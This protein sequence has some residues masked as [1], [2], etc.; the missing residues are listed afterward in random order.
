[1]S[2]ILLYHPFF[3]QPITYIPCYMLKREIILGCNAK[4]E[5]IMKRARLT[6]IKIIF[7]IVCTRMLAMEIDEDKFVNPSSMKSSTYHFDESELL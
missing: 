4:A 1:M 2:Y 6:H 5:D 7:T 3:C